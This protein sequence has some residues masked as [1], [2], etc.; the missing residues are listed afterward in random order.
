MARKSAT[1]TRP[2][3]PAPPAPRRASEPTRARA[4]ALPPDER[5]AAIVEATLPLLLEHGTSVTTRQIAEAAGIAEGTIFRVFPDKD[6]LIAAVVD[7]AFD[8]APTDAALD[9][10][11]RGLGFEDRLVEAVE[12]IRRRVELIFHLMTA[13]EMTK[14]PSGHSR[15]RHA[16]PDMTALVAVIEPD[17]DQLRRTPV[18]MADLLRSMTFA[19]TLPALVGEHPLSSAEIVSVLLDG[20][21]TRPRGRRR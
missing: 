10:I 6:S 21:R 17:R 16:R 1:P 7:A 14:P 13:V 19:C 20:V 5:R 8:P 3:P 12:I 11:D 4:S 9:Q 2:A 15:D 18:E